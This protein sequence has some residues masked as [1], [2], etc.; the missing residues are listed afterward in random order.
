[1]ALTQLQTYSTLTDTSASL[2]NGTQ[3]VFEAVRSASVSLDV[4]VDLSMAFVDLQATSLKGLQATSSQLT[5]ASFLHRPDCLLLRPITD[6][7]HLYKKSL[8]S[9]VM[10]S[11]ISLAIRSGSQRNPFFLPKL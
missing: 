8:L 11:N 2:A 3:K 10:S 1:M 6:K 5:E 7:Y 9:I 4:V